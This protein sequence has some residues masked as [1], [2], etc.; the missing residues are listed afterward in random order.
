M[1]LPFAQPGFCVKESLGQ[2][3]FSRPGKQPCGR[4]LTPILFFNAGLWF[5]WLN[6]AATHQSMRA[7][8]SC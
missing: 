2:A 6:L 5:T 8:K 3:Q 7:A 4:F 1:K